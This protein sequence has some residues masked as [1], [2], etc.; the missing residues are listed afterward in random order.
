MYPEPSTCILPGLIPG[1]M[2]IHIGNGRYVEYE[3][4]RILEE[5]PNGYVAVDGSGS[6]PLPKS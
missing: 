5:Q 4:K 1:R 6:I 3:Y 2:L